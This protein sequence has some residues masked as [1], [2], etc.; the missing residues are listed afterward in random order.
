MRSL[1]VVLGAEL[2]QLLRDVNTLLFSVFFPLFLFP[3]LIWFY[4]QSME[5]VVGWEESLR[6]RVS[7]PAALAAELPDTLQIVGSGE[8]ADAT[9]LQEGGVIRVAY[10][11][12]D[13]VSALA[14]RR[15][16]DALDDPWEIDA[17]DVAPPDEALT[18]VMARVIPALLVILA[19]MASLYPA[20]EAVVAD[21]ERGTLETT[22]VTASPRWVFVAG[23]LASVGVI[24][25]VAM[26]ATGAGA[27]VT[28]GHLALVSGASIGIPPL[29][30]LI[31]LPVG[32]VTAL[33]GASLA[34]VAAAPTRS[35]KQAQNTSTGAASVVMFAAML[36]MLPRASL[37]EGFGWLPVTNA[38]LVM[39]ELLL[40][41]SPG[42]WVVV[43]LGQLVI[44][45]TVATAWTARS[46]GKLEVR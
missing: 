45:T 34:L 36:G 46:L 25:L 8:P 12:A 21:R 22:L 40:G 18:G 9:I 17:H 4:S 13:P 41:H 42:L 1:R 27:L 43:A 10:R 29:R 32:A 30:L 6:P 14:Q 7:A 35:F 15:V 23:K 3:G 24:T 33:T 11:S 5:F 31:A 28:L 38:I 44:I 19:V 37:D 20:V 39:R 16:M 26:V 2:R